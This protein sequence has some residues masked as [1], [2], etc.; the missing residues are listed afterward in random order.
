MSSIFGQLMKNWSAQT[1]F[2]KIMDMTFIVLGVLLA[3]D[4]VLAFTLIGTSLTF[5]AFLSIWILLYL[6]V[7]T[8]A[9]KL[10]LAIEEE[11]QRAILKYWAVAWILGIFLFSLSVIYVL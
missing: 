6:M 11:D 4:I 10:R 8:L 1:R 3:I 7:V 5:D 2:A 9:L